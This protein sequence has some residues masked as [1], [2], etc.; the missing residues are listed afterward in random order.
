MTLSEQSPISG[1][2][3]TS[4]GNPLIM[5][6]FEM[7]SIPRSF[8]QINKTI[9]NHHTLAAP[10]VVHQSPEKKQITVEDRGVTCLTRSMCNDKAI[11]FCMLIT[12]LHA[13]L[14]RYS[15]ELPSCHS[16]L[17]KKRK[18]KKHTQNTFIPLDHKHC[19]QSTQTEGE[20]A[21][22]DLS[23]SLPNENRRLKYFKHENQIIT[24]HTVFTISCNKAIV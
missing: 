13:D 17:I 19:R 11:P 16:H 1:K 22:V 12:H 14:V 18:R 6:L 23:V 2:I 9:S 24:A 21:R 15:P 8:L 7:L 20:Q 5:G 4:T 10:S 3:T